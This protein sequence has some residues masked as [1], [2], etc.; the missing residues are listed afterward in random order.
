MKKLLVALVICTALIFS[1][2]AQTIR[3][4]V[5]KYEFNENGG[6]T[7]GGS[8]ILITH[9]LEI[10]P[11]GTVELSA[12]GYQTQKNLIGT[13]KISG[14]KL[15]IYFKGY[16]EQAG[17]MFTPY[18]GNELLLTLEKR[19]IKGRLVIWTTFAEYESA[20]GNTNKKGGIY[21][22]RSKR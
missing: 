20:L 10:R 16:D 22:R 1:A 21:F 3:D 13:A 11:D 15:N 2:N 14:G 17:N 8:A 6:R 18:Q 12:N 5:G 7:T 9:D 19:K 4:F